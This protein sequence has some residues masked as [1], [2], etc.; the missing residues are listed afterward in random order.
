M[1][2]TIIKPK[3][4]TV[5]DYRADRLE[6]LLDQRNGSLRYARLLQEALF[7]DPG[8]LNEIFPESF[9]YYSARDIVGGDFYWFEKIG[10]KAFVACADCTGHGV[11]GAMLSVLGVNK[12]HE[13]IGLLGIT[14]PAKILDRLNNSIYK[15]LA[16]KQGIK[17]MNDGMDIALYSI[18]LDSNMLEYA[19]A[20]NPIYII[21]NRDLFEIKP[22]KQ[23]IGTSED[24]E[25]Y[26]NHTFQLK[27]GDMIYSFSDGYFDQFG[28]EKGKKFMAKQFK[29]L[30]TSIS[31]KEIPVQ[32]DTLDHTIKTWMGKYDQVDDIC[33]VG[34]RV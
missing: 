30:L 22:D 3:A 29:N 1:L 33:I 4:E 23:G 13:T 10:N 11:P 31:E 8:T 16:K 14:N 19:G 18:D 26:E 25:L 32:K 15:A 21:R 28:G 2:D 7:H 34:V 17:K 24:H 6:E 27:K 9:I 5:H 12:L 20:N